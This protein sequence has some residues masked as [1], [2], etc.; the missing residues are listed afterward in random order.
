VG[1]QG[2]DAPIEFA[3][4]IHLHAAARREEQHERVSAPVR[5]EEAAGGSEEGQHE[6]FGEELPPEAGG[7]GADGETHAH[8]VAASEG[9]DEEQIADVGAGDEQDADDDDQHGLQG[10]EQGG[11]VVERCLPQ[12]P[13]S[14]AA[15]AIGGGVGGFQALRDRGELLLSLLLGDAGLEPRVGFYPARTAI[16]ELVAAALEG[17]FHGNGYPEVHAPA[18]KG[19]VKAFGATPTMVCT[20]PS[21]RSVLPMICGSPRKRPRQS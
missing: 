11:G 2:E 10:G 16:F 9:A 4:E 12:G 15:S 3:G 1:A 14:H 18:D 5:G 13:E 20:A 19:T 6:A 8:F 7:A 21:R 17:V